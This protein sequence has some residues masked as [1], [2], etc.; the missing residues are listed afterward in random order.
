MKYSVHLLEFTSEIGPETDV[1]KLREWCREHTSIGR[2]ACIPGRQ[3][4]SIDPSTFMPIGPF[5][6]IF[7]FDLEEDRNWFMLKWA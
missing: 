1:Y 2:Y 4:V 5:P 3:T 7:G 6:H